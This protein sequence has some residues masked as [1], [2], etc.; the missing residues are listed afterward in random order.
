MQLAIAAAFKPSLIHNCNVWTEHLIKVVIDFG[1]IAIIIFSCIISSSTSL[2]VS[3]KPSKHLI[4][5]NIVTYF[6]QVKNYTSFGNKKKPQ[7]PNKKFINT[8][9]EPNRIYYLIRCSTVQ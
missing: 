1:S 3:S 4:I 5:I 7:S 9:P 2:F 6:F 8:S